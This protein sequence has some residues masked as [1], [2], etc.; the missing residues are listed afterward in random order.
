MRN[1]RIKFQIGRINQILKK[2]LITGM[3]STRIIRFK[4]KPGSYRADGCKRQSLIDQCFADRIA[5]LTLIIN[6]AHAHSRVESIIQYENVKIVHLVPHSYLIK[7]I[8][9]EWSTF[10]STVNYKL[11]QQMTEMVN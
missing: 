9:L 3:T 7:P 8:E 5:K 1:R 6:N 2:T 4:H 11:R 10:K